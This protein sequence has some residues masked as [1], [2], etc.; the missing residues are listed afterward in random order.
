[1]RTSRKL[2][3]VSATALA[4][5]AS[6]LLA[7]AAIASDSAPPGTPTAQS[8]AGSPLVGAVFIGGQNQPHTCTGVVLDSPHGDLLVTA[9]H[10]ITGDGVGTSFA[11]GYTQGKTPYGVWSVQHAYAAPAWVN[12]Q[13]PLADFVVLQV[14]PQQMG[15]TSATLES[16][17]GGLPVGQAALTS[18]ERDV[19]VMG[20]VAGSNDNP[21]TCAAP[22]GQT[23][24]YPT[25]NCHGFFDGS[26]GSPFLWSDR[27]RAPVLVGVLGGLHQGGCFE[28]NSFSAPFDAT[29]YR[30]LAR[31]TNNLSADTL[32]TP[33]SPNC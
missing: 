7:E 28:W 9:A 32:P 25:F 26:S 8:F 19:T 24:G 30:V 15:Q 31:A 14:A 27:G 13:D 29:I 2:F 17:T 5:L 22:L 10:C 11:P 6:S 21:V 3:L 16:V 20:Y 23:Q 33:G 18:A 1:M 12:G 4:I